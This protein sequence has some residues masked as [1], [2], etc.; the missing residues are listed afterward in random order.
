MAEVCRICPL[1]LQ[2]STVYEDGRVLTFPIDQC[3]KTV[4]GEEL[5]VTY[6]MGVP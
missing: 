3:A 2:V 1:L 5:E 6:L 4:E